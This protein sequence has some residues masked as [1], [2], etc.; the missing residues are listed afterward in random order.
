MS[1]FVRLFSL[2]Y[3]MLQCD[4]ILLYLNFNFD[5]IY[6]FYKILSKYFMV[7][8]NS[9]EDRKLKGINKCMENM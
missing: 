5:S 3:H 4:F 7:E 2:S 8:N 6:I 1:G 9:I